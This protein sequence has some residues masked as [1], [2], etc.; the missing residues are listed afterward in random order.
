M[1]SSSI[2]TELQTCIF[3]HECLTACV[4]FYFKFP[5]NT[6]KTTQLG[7][8]MFWSCFL[9]ACDVMF[10]F[11][12]VFMLRVAVNDK[13]LFFGNRIFESPEALAKLQ[14]IK[15]LIKSTYRSGAGADAIVDT[16]Q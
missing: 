5:F 9:V 7:K 15:D 16:S 4:T 10:D 11:T 3:L 2:N 8:V 14:D 12:D 1:F 6:K 13:L